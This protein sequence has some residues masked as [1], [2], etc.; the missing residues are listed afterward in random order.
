MSENR[1]GTRS[2]HTA[3]PLPKPRGTLICVHNRLAFECSLCRLKPKEQIKCP[4]NIPSTRCVQCKE[5]IFKPS[6]ITPGAANLKNNELSSASTGDITNAS[7]SVLSNSFNSNPVNNMS[8]IVQNPPAVDSNNHTPVNSNNKGESVPPSV[9]PDQSDKVTSDPAI[10]VPTT[11]PSNMDIQS[12]PDEEGWIQVPVTK[13]KKQDSLSMTTNAPGKKK[14]R[15]VVDTS[16]ITTNLDNKFDALSSD[17]GNKDQ[18]KPADPKPGPILIQ[19]VEQLDKFERWLD[20]IGVKDYTL[21]NIGDKL[22]IQCGTIPEFRT[23]QKALMERNAYMIYFDAKVEKPYKVVIKGIHPS[24]TEEAIKGELEK[25][26]F[27]VRRVH[28]GQKKVLEPVQAVKDTAGPSEESAT[29]PTEESPPQMQKRFL[30]LQIV[31]V[32]LEK[33]ETVQSIHKLVGLFHQTVT[34]ESPRKTHW[35]PMCRRCQRYGHVKCNFPPRCVKCLGSHLSRDCDKTVPFALCCNCGEKHPSNYRKCSYAIKAN[36][37]NN[38]KN[39]KT[40]PEHD[41][42]IPAPST[43]PATPASS[44]PPAQS[45]RNPHA[46]PAVSFTQSATSNINPNVSFSAVTQGVSPHPAPQTQNELIQQLLAT[47]E[48]LEKRLER[49]EELINKQHQQ[50]VDLMKQLMARGKK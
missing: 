18:E 37:R 49:Q 23:L 35:L 20:N 44:T 28:R 27:K 14:H 5:L 24:I 30:P 29:K 17:Q 45:A 26:G 19:Q 11:N 6:K 22:R 42:P 21:K 2:G 4:H 10:T 16:S 8:Q 7:A 13:Q 9:V 3:I 41:Y 33:T 12:T 34:V 32:D 39:R 40:I 31:F 38:L 43:P 46:T 47:Q 48:R 36:S 15:Q 1:I 50:I 25:K